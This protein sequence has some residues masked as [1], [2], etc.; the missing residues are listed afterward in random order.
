[1]SYN[2][3]L[4][5]IDQRKHYILRIVE[6]PGIIHGNYKISRYPMILDELNIPLQEILVNENLT[7]I[8]NAHKDKQTE[9]KL[10]RRLKK[11][12]SGDRRFVIFINL[13]VDNPS[14]ISNVANL[15]SV[16]K[17]INDIYYSHP[18]IALACPPNLIF[19]TEQD[20][21][22]IH[23]IYIDLLNQIAFNTERKLVYFIPSYF[24]ISQ[25]E[26]LINWY[27]SKYGDDGLFAVDCSG[28]RFS[29][30]CYK[31]VAIVHRKMRSE[32]I[33]D[34]G[35]YLFDSKPHKKT[36]KSSPSEELLS[37]LHGVNL[38]G[39]LH[40]NIVIP[41]HVVEKL[42]QKVQSYAKV[43]TESTYLYEPKIG[44]DYIQA[45]IESDRGVDKVLQKDILPNKDIDA[46]LSQ[47]TRTIFLNEL[48]KLKRNY[49]KVSQNVGLS[50]FF[51]I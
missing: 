17:V 14:L 40:S 28:D 2:V 18:S 49:D 1:M 47:G 42:R 7:D 45:Q 36:S 16:A 41:P 34:Y 13:R 37:I 50:S 8:L 15:S 22:I 20:I 4:K 26:A 12:I 24:S 48:K 29:S 32:K 21:D 27:R 38:I 6:L 5:D 9:D 35:I 3:K 30:E 31:H 11:K 51:N 19:E 23:Q 46:L 33:Q 44:V 43:F 10:T 25:K 39:P